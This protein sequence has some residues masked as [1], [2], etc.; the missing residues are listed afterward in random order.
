MIT[1][2][3]GNEAG[4]RKEKR[5]RGRGRNEVNDTEELVSVRKGREQGT[6]G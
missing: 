2:E 3:A 1:K 5:G 4:A 6:K